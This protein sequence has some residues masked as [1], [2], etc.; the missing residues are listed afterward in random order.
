[1]ASE[2]HL[3]AF[4]RYLD[5]EMETEERA[6]F[7]RQLAGDEELR[8]ELNL[9]KMAMQSLEQDKY[10]RLRNELMDRGQQHQQRGRGP[11]LWRPLSIAASLALVAFASYYLL[12]TGG[13]ELTP[14]ALATTAAI[15]EKLQ[16][17]A[18]SGKLSGEGNQGWFVAHRLYQ[19]GKCPEAITALQTLI[20]DPLFKMSYKGQQ[21]R[22]MIGYCLIEGGRGGEAIE[23]L[24]SIPASTAMYR[25]ATWCL[26][27]AQLQAGQREA[28]ERTFK[29]IAKDRQNA[30]HRSAFEILDQLAQSRE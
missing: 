18:I 10:Q 20:E 4:D 2:E 14:P 17:P 7:E 30:H 12:F 1:M 27:F 16:R 19:K 11:S 21:S 28:A 25:E 24:L 9:R 6:D 3:R 5:R 13:P 23:T 26:A 8:R 22:L 15:F 29:R